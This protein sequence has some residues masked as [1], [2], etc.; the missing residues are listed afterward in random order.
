MMIFSVLRKDLINTKKI[1]IF[2]RKIDFCGR[3][4]RI[5]LQKLTNK[6][7]AQCY[8]YCWL[9]EGE[10]EPKIFDAK[11]LKENLDGESKIIAVA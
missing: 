11:F 5:T 6:Y 7:I 10:K 9:E 8:A 3:Q 4:F 1:Y 2:L